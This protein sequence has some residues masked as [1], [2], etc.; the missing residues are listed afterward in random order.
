MSSLQ[1]KENLIEIIAKFLLQRFSSARCQ[2]KLIAIQI[3]VC[4]YLFCQFTGLKS[5]KLYKWLLVLRFRFTCVKPPNKISSKQMSLMSTSWATLHTCLPLLH[6]MLEINIFYRLTLWTKKTD[7]VKLTAKPTTLKSLP[8]TD[9]ALDFNILHG[10]IQ[11]AH[12]HY[13]VTREP[14][15]LDK[16][17]FGFEEDSSNP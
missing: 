11:G 3:A 4:G 15:K 5:Y 9:Q 13:S 1:T 10:H 14:P 7:N 16:C 12:Q 2:H 17:K 6:H 8:P